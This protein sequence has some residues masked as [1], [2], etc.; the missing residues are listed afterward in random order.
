MKF[1]LTVCECVFEWE[2]KIL[3]A[4]DEGRR[5]LGKKKELKEHNDAAKRYKLWVRFGESRSK[6]KKEEW[7]QSR[8]KMKSK[9]IW[10]KHVCSGYFLYFNESHRLSV[11]AILIYTTGVNIFI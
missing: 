5:Q 4:E 7:K 3:L 8:R 11:L 1:H 2:K 6:L 9:T 10:G